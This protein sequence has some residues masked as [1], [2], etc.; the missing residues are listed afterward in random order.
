[1]RCRRILPKRRPRD[2]PVHILKRDII[3][4]VVELRPD[5]KLHPLRDLR[6]LV[7]VPVEI[8]FSVEP[9]RVAAQIAE[10]AKQRLR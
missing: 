2:V 4:Y 6:V 9:V 5:L 1:M 3:E 8:H 10:I 7:N